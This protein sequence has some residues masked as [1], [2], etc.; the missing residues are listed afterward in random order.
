MGLPV[1]RTGDLLTRHANRTREPK[2][3]HIVKTNWVIDSAK[4]ETLHPE[5]GKQQPSLIALCVYR[6]HHPWDGRV[7]APQSLNAFFHRPPSL[8]T[9]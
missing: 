8:C 2:Y 7:Q 6:A 1:S 9:A 3:R 4:G 5:A